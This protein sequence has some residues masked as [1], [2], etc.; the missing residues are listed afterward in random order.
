MEEITPTKPTRKN[1][2]Q[3]NKDKFRKIAKRYYQERGGKQKKEQYYEVN[4]DVIIQRS[5][6]RYQANR[7]AILE[8]KRMKR[9]QENF[10]QLKVEEQDGQN[11]SDNAIITTEPTK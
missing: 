7:E 6:D 1:Y 8:A 10:S 11:P 3:L 5:K 9:L 2:Y 4:K